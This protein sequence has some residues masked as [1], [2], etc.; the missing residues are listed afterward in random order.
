MK[1]RSLESDSPVYRNND[2]FGCQAAF[3]AYAQNSLRVLL[4]HFFGA[5]SLGRER[6]VTYRQEF[7]AVVSHMIIVSPREV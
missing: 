5:K 6:L 2:S 3:V 7:N 1:G 4:S